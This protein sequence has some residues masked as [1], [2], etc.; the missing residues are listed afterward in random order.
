II[1]IATA[2]RFSDSVAVLLANPKV[3]AVPVIKQEN[4][5][6]RLGDQVAVNVKVFPDPG[7]GIP[8]GTVI[9]RDDNLYLGSGN[10]DAGGTTTITA[11]FSRLGPH[12]LYADYSGD[13]VFGL[14]TSPVLIKHVAD[15]TLTVV[16]PTRP[17]RGT[18][19]S[20][21]AREREITIQASSSSP[22][23]A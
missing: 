8:T 1:D 18:N 16:R 7:F 9:L 14:F 5:P 6:V 15:I 12:N 23:T 17:Q 11:S 20:V 10:L 3:L 2:D 22:M 19:G 4:D 13:N 21:N